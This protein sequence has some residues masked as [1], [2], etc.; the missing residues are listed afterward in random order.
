MRVKSEIGAQVQFW[1]GVLLLHILASLPAVAA[2]V[3]SRLSARITWLTN[4]RSRQVTEVNLA[5]CFPDRSLRQRQALAK[6]SLYEMSAGIIDMARCWLHGRSELESRISRVK[7]RE[8][9]DEAVSAGAGTLV[10]LPHLGSWEIV[11][12]YLARR[13]K[14]TALYREPKTRV[15]ADYIRRRRER[16]GARLM[17]IGTA[18]LRAIMRTLEANDM[19][20]LLPD[21]VPSPQSGQFAPFFGEPTSTMTLAGNLIRRSGAKAVCAYCKR[22]P[23]GRYELVFRPVDNAIYDTGCAS[24]LTGLNR[25]IEACVLDCP[26]QYQWEYKRFKYLPDGRKRDHRMARSRRR[27]APTSDSSRAGGVISN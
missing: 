8:Y 17:P 20:L 23:G 5:I 1:A 6:A 12:L 27:T 19:A 9:L 3:V 14:T 22:L 7:G 13:H 26:E 18:G 2:T 15:Y 4:G 25:S 16:H 11:S 10:L 21:Q 24:S